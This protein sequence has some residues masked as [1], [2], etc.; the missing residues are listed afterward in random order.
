MNRYLKKAVAVFAILALAGQGCTKAPSQATTQAS[1]PI[2]INVWGVVDGFSVYSPIFDAYRA[3]HPYVSFNYRR[4]RL[5]EYEGEL[6]NA[7]AEDRGPDIFLIHNTWT[8]K[9][10]PK[11]SSL[12]PS[13]QVAYRVQKGRTITYEL[14]QEP[15]ISGR[16]FKAQYAD[17]VQ[18]DLLRTLNVGTASTPNMQERL[19]G[20]PTNV[21]TMGMY[22]NKDILNVANIP[23]P[24][25]TWTEFASQVPQ[26]T[27]LDANGNIIQ[28]AAGIG[29][30]D[31]ID[32][33]TDLLTALMVQNGTEMA[34]A[35][36]SPIFHQIPPALRDVRTEPPSY[37]AVT[38]YTDFANPAK[39]T[40]TWNETMPNALDAFVQ[41]QTAFYFGYAYDYD[42]IRSRAP[43]LNLG[44]APLPQIAGNPPKNI[45]NYW[46]FAVS[47]KSQ[48]QD[49]A[50]NFLNSLTNS[51]T[52]T[53]ILASSHEP[54]AKKDLL[55]TQ[56]EDERVGVFA[57][58]VLTAFS[59]YRGSSPTQMEDALKEL[60]RNIRSG[61][62]INDAMRFAAEKIA[63]TIR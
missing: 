2:T 8:N 59:W 36:G 47:K 24:P 48:H 39:E 19:V 42:T 33:S 46:Y 31:N 20:I 4:F 44:I 54:S 5:E 62:K 15:T 28:S 40:Y 43:K 61:V 27:Q 51:D 26:L 56:I 22:Y 30:A 35:N 41:G 3:L 63:Q 53:Q 21:D 12:P 34:D 11:I 7:L 16:E 57:S 1:Q 10:L 23:T 52:L 14:R 32:R 18:N 29:T 58:Q 37:Q 45:A 25:T 38:F 55:T 49:V 17:V 60:I 50:W 6:L 13:A 9:Y